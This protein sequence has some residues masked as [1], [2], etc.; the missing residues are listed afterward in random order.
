MDVQTENTQTC[1]LLIKIL[2]NK[3][4][5]FKAL[6]LKLSAVYIMHMQ[7]GWWM[8][9]TSTITLLFYSLLCTN[10]VADMLCADTSTTK[11]NLQ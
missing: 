10:A 11:M 3:Q 4:C 5:L 1:S 2:K 9:N 7:V 8:L 6:K